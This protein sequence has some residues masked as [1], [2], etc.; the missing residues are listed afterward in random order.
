MGDLLASRLP[1]AVVAQ[2]QCR[3]RLSAPVWTAFALLVAVAIS[4]LLGHAGS[5][6]WRSPPRSASASLP[7]AGRS[8]R[9]VLAGGARVRRCRGPARQHRLRSCAPDHPPLTVIG[10]APLW[11]IAIDGFDPA[12]FDAFAGISARD[13]SASR[14]GSSRRTRRS[15]ARGRP[16]RRASRRRT[17]S[18]GPRPDASRGSRALGVAGGAA[19]QAT[20]PPPISCGSRGRRSPAA[21]SAV[22]NRGGRRGPDRRRTVGDVAGPG[23]GSSSPIA[24][25]CGSN[26]AARLPRS[27]G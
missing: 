6:R 4:L 1:D 11:V 3:I 9:V 19:A 26:R 18:M 8:W 22:R 21:T 20:V 12:M 16:S 23:A 13:S 25:C 10:G 17:A 2:R 15:R 24:R 5:R 14:C 7:P 27:A